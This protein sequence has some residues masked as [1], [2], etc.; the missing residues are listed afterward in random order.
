[1]LNRLIEQGVPEAEARKWERQAPELLKQAGGPDF[2]Q[3]AD[4]LELLELRRS[5]D[6]PPKFQ[7]LSDG[8]LLAEGLGFEDFLSDALRRWPEGAGR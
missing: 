4:L 3:A 5:D 7:L 1:M 8:V 2:T 6:T